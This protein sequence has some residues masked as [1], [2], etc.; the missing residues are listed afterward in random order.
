MCGV[1]NSS[2]IHGAVRW[3]WFQWCQ[4]HTLAAGLVIK[5]DGHMHSIVVMMMMTYYMMMTY[6]YMMMST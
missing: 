1:G 3:L 6:V 2:V 5:G 4:R